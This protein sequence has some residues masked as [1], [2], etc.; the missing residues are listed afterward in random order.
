M[1]W[2]TFNGFNLAT[3]ARKR[4]GGP[5]RLEER[6]MGNRMYFLKESGEGEI[7]PIL[8]LSQALKDSQRP[9]ETRHK[10]A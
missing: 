10:L 6:D 9:Q 3:F 4:S 2:F 1:V 8:D 5:K 7:Q